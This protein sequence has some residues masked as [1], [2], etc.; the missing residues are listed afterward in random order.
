MRNDHKQAN[1]RYQKNSS[2]MLEC[3]QTDL[4]DLHF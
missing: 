1:G 2:H 3:R 4:V